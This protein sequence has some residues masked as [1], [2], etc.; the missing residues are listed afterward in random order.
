M[1]RRQSAFGSWVNRSPIGPGQ[2]R[3][4]LDQSVDG[5]LVAFES[6]RRSQLLPGIG[7]LRDGA[8]FRLL[9][10]RGGIARH[11]QAEMADVFA[12]LATT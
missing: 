8:E 3:T 1:A 2:L 7:E 4:S 6:I 10:D 11:R 5:P 9:V 12:C